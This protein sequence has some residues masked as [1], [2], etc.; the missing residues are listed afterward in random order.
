MLMTR[1]DGKLSLNNTHTIMGTMHTEIS[2]FNILIV[3]NI[4]CMY[5][6][7]Y[8]HNRV[9]RFEKLSKDNLQYKVYMLCERHKKKVN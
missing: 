6:K 8:L 5:K 1:S 4:L 3:E 2:T 7:Y 9:K